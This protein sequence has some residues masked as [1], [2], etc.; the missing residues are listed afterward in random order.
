MFSNETL[1]LIFSLCNHKTKAILRSANSRTL[2]LV[3]NCVNK[4]LSCNI[5]VTYHYLFDRIL[6]PPVYRTEAEYTDDAWITN[7]SHY[8]EHIKA[9]HIYVNISEIPICSDCGYS[10]SE[11]PQYKILNHLRGLLTSHIIEKY[12]YIIFDH[13]FDFELVEECLPFLMKLEEKGHYLVDFTE[14]YNSRVVQH[15]NNTHYIKKL[16]DI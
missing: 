5:S 7:Y 6:F 11:E 16:F 14:D 4:E 10:H 3:D 15:S 12:T 1:A 13:A 9:N 8:C 2:A